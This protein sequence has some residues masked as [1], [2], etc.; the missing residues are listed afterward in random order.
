[1]SGVLA[2][3]RASGRAVLLITHEVAEAAS[4]DRVVVLAEGERA[5]EGPPAE[6]LQLGDAALAAWGLELP[7]VGVLGA[8][9]RALGVQ[10]P[11]EAMTPESIGGA[12]WR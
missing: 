3:V 11:L 9:L 1:V 8:R 5:F 6:L 4:A 7:A 10:V 12:L 2:N